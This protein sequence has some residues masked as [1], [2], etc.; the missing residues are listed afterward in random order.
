[1]HQL[2]RRRTIYLVAIA[3]GF[4]VLVLAW[5]LHQDADPYQRY[6]HLVQAGFLLWAF[7]A[8]WRKWV[9]VQRVERATYWT[10]SVLWV[11]NYAVGLHSG[12]A[13]GVGW[14]QFV[15][16]VMV[17]FFVLAALSH[18]MFATLMAV[19]IN[20]VMFAAC[21]MVGLA[22]LVPDAL[23]GL[24][25]GELV[26][27]FQ[28][29]IAL[30]V[31]I[32]FL[33]VLAKSKDDHLE[34]ELEARALGEFALKDSLTGLPN[35]RHV[36]RE[37]DRLVEIGRRYGR[38][39]SLISFDLDHFKN[40]NDTLGHPVGDE[41]L[42]AVAARAKRHLR[43]SDTLGRWGGEEFLILAAE[44]DERFASTLAERVREAIESGTYPRGI[45]VTASFGVV[46]ME[47]GMTR[48]DLLREVDRRLYAA[49]DAGRNRVEV[50]DAIA[51]AAIVTSGVLSED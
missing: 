40:I 21:L 26:S 49:K 11:G 30:A 6:A 38:P 10:L 28:F 36:V 1:M 4:P 9:P 47:P 46:T 43:R 14:G 19:R 20:L 17:N 2:S 33:Y 5:W 35:R 23:L 32:G 34:A 50:A 31:V 18:L 7:G 12:Q 48:A 15:T 51:P 37:L 27:L 29:C 25:R 8:L 45:H 24:H 3:L 22:R 16:T 42:I 13:F 39:V 41:V 44:T